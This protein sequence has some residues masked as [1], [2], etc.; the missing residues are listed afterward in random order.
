M[1]VDYETPDEFFKILDDEFSFTID[2]CANAQNKKLENYI[3]DSQNS[4]N[5]IW[6]GVCWLNPPYNKQLSH[7][8]RKAYYSAQKGATVVCLLSA[9][10]TGTKW[11]HDFVMKSTEIRFVEGRIYFGS[12]GKFK[13]PD[14]Y[15]MVVVFLPYCKGPPIV[16]SFKL[17]GGKI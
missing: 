14:Y 10:S 11:F 16:S 3:S 17:K 5:C 1:Y 2:L 12:N 13:R 7:W 6:E 8:I 4:L 15:S 9:R